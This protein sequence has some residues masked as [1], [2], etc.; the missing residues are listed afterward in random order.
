MRQIVKNPDRTGSGGWERGR[1]S[2]CLCDLADCACACLRV[3]G[4]RAGWEIMYS[5]LGTV[6]FEA[7]VNTRGSGM[8]G[9][10][11]RESSK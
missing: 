4:N 1:N 11:F 10:G 5:F 6:K 3:L 8:M 2:L 9:Q 7:S